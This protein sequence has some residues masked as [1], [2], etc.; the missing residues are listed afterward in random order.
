MH[1]SHTVKE[2]VKESVAGLQVGVVVVTKVVAFGTTS[3]MHLGKRSQV[4]LESDSS[5]VAPTACVLLNQSVSR[6]IFFKK[7]L[8]CPFLLRPVREASPW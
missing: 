5:I 6:G 1:Q 2:R 8:L 4:P 3:E 7:R